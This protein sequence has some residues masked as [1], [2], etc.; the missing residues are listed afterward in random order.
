[1]RFQRQRRLTGRSGPRAPTF[2][3]L[4]GFAVCG[5]CGGAVS[6]E[7]KTWGSKKPGEQ[8]A[9]VK[10]YLCKRHRQSGAPACA[11]AVRRPVSVVDGLLLKWLIANVLTEDLIV[12]TMGEIR[13]RLVARSK[14]SARDATALEKRARALRGEIERLGESLLATDAKPAVIVKM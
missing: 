10:L 8:R 4:S 11:N 6:A 3:L 14:T 13:R 5:I 12:Q 1:E 7:S 2:H 9:R